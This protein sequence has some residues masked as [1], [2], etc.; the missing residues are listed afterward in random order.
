MEHGKHSGRQA[1]PYYPGASLI[2]DE[3][4]NLTHTHS[5]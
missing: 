4:H 3:A 2:K 5:Q 1:V